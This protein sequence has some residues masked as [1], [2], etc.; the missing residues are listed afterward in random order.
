MNAM[1]QRSLTIGWTLALIGG[2]IVGAMIGLICNGRL[3]YVTP[4]EYVIRTQTDF[5]ISLVRCESTR[6]TIVGGESYVEV[7]G[8]SATYPT[9]TTGGYRG[10]IGLD[11]LGREKLI[12]AQ[13]WGEVH[14]QGRE[15]HAGVNWVTAACLNA[16]PTS[17]LS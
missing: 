4:D 1:E 5:G 16:V 6:T 14:F 2:C 17:A 15:T 7:K 9:P 3:A 11:Q 12:P 13:L 8:A 10:W